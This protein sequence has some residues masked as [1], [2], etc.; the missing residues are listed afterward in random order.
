ML[1]T[2]MGRVLTLCVL[3]PLGCDRGNGRGTMNEAPAE[4]VRAGDAPP[5]LEMK[6]MAELKAADGQDIEG[7]IEMSDTGAGVRVMAKIENAEPGM[8]GIHIHQLGNCSDIKGKSMGD[9]FAPAS[10]EHALPNEATARHLGDLGNIQVSE[11]GKGELE[12][13]VPGANLR[14]GDPKS[15]LGR[16]LVLHLGKDSG[17][18]QQ[19]SGG[20]GEPIAC[21]VIEES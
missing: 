9:H 17:K 6:A 3:L 15:F 1:N 16:A 21:G 14:P 13:T 4:A 5:P 8:H 7:E 12:I 11:E 20:S 18:S 19:P 2:S 10:H